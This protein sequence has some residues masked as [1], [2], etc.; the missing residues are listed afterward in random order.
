M[1]VRIPG[2]Y[3]GY[4]KLLLAILLL[5]CVFVLPAQESGTIPRWE[6][7][8][9]TG[10]LI[11]GTDD[12]VKILSQIRPKEWIQDGAPDAYVTQ[13]E[14]LEADISNLANS[15]RALERQ[16]EKLSTTV[17]T[18]LW[19]DRVGSMLTSMSAGV[20]KYQNSSLGNLLD[21]AAGRVISVE[22]RLK[23]YMRQLVIDQ[24]A[25]LDIANSEA[26]RCRQEMLK[27]PMTPD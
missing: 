10:T 13:Y 18:F 21:S 5:G 20:R 19:M 23:E 27:R 12:I 25:E 6:V 14:T 11:A 8:E 1:S 2:L 7:I 22:D 9:M 17:D 24:E 4:M 26:Q 16:P 3:D 15:A